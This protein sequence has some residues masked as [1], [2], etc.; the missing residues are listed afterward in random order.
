MSFKSLEIVRKYD[1]DFQDIINDFYLP[2]L[3]QTKNYSRIAGFFTSSSLLISF[4]GMEKMIKSS[5]EMRLIVSPRLSP[6]DVEALSADKNKMSSMIEKTFENELN[7]L[8]HNYVNSEELLGW[9]FA[10]GFLNIKIAVIKG[11]HGYLTAEEVED[12]G[13]FHQKVGIMEDGYGNFITYSG[14]INETAQAWLNNNEEFKTFKSWDGEQNYYC[15]LDIEKFEDYWSGH[16]GNTEIYEFPEALRQKL[17]SKAL[18]N[19][20]YPGRELFKRIKRK[21]KEISLFPYQKEAMA[22]W[23]ANDKRLL[24]EMATG[25]G[26]TRTAVACVQH[27]LHDNNNEHN[28]I[29]I[30]VPEETL[31]IQWRDE[32]LKHSLNFDEVVL[33]PGKDMNWPD[34]LKGIV[35]G[36]NVG[37]LANAAVITIHNTA[38]APRFLNIIATMKKNKVRS[39]FIGDEVHA[40]GAGTRRNALA[41]IYD[42]RIGLSATPSRW[43]D[44]DGT[45]V[46]SEYF[47]NK[48][49]NFGILEALTTQNPLTEKTFLTDYY[50]YPKAI[51]LKEEE[52]ENYVKLTKQINKMSFIKKKGEDTTALNRLMQRRANIIKSASGKLD[53]LKEILIDEIGIDNVK[54]LLIFVSPELINGVME[55]LTKL[56]ICASRFTKDQG[57]KASVQF[58]GRSERQ[59]II[60]QFKEE[61]IQAIVAIKCMDEGIDIPTATTAILVSSTTNPREYIQRIGRVIRRSDGKK[62]ANIYDLIIAV[63]DYD[64]INDI[65]DIVSRREM[66]RGEYIMNFAINNADA[67]NEL[68]RIRG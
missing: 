38:S 34:T 18:V 47:G 3:E 55:L 31:A 21:E 67:L 25:T 45:A 57:K 64:N 33:V 66:D 35:G 60:D 52:V 61:H 63:S 5:G 1:S 68:Y 10:N 30:S 13:L 32:L 43:F 16:R 11:A 48:S 44:E 8:E 23:L 20:E 49:F 39:L 59:F 53:V 41:E 65:K 29:I 26:K 2:V 24:F 6:K 27:E 40:L 14:S 17:I 62:Y 54:N 15:N 37:M 9:L 12:S 7:A 28:L 4:R 36:L 22:E 51:Y 46:I 50:Y 56:N 19:I 58:G 42:S